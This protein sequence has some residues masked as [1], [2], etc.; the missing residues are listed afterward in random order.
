MSRVTAV[1]ATL[2]GT[3]ALAGCA[4]PAP[5]VEPPIRL[6]PVP[7]PDTVTACLRGSMTITEADGGR[8]V[9]VTT[10][11]TVAVVLHGSAGQPWAPVTGTGAALRA[12]AGGGSAEPAGTTSARFSAVAPGTATLTSSRPACPSPAA[13]GVSC[14][15]RLGFQVTVVVR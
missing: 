2:T 7:S 12:G 4:H 13:G 10:G 14:L 6:T 8:S 11:S 15:A 5:R 9:C 3:L 1:V